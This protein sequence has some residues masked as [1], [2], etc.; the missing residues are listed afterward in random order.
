ML[1]QEE[2]NAAM[3]AQNRDERMRRLDEGFNL[4][5]EEYMR[6]LDRLAT[7]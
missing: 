6:V 4:L 2:F 7:A 3:V 1:S 5:E